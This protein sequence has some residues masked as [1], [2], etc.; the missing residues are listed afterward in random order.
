[1]IHPIFIFGVALFGI[2][3]GSEYAEPAFLIC[4][5]VLVLGTTL[6]AMVVLGEWNAQRKAGEA[7]R[8][9]RGY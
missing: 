8:R 7:Y 4:M 2:L 5:G 9:A 3:A 1:M 6:I